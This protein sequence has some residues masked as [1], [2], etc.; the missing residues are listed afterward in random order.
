VHPI[1]LPN[2]AR[3]EVAFEAVRFAYPS[4]PEALCSTAYRWRPAG[5]EGSRIVVH[6]APE[7]HDLSSAVALLPTRSPAP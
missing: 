6:P 4:R 2:P 7:E 3:G 5:R 1:A